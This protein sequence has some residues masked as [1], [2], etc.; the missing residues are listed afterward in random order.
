MPI[1]CLNGYYQFGKTG[2]K[3]H[4]IPNNKLSRLIA[5]SKAIKQMKAI[6]S[7]S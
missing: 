2:K 7:R 3:Y 5:K 1:R 6:K 4:Y